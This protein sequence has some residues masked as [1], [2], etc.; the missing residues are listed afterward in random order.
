MSQENTT[1]L[2]NT[3]LFKDLEGLCKHFQI[4]SNVLSILIVVES[5]E[6]ANIPI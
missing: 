5:L 2:Q 1:L 6:V 4:F 3:S